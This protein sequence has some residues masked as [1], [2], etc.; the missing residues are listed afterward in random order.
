MTITGQ[1]SL[2][3]ED[4]E[5]MVRDAE[6]HAEDDRRR[7]EEAEV[8]NN[9]DTLVYQTEKLLRE[10]GEKAS[11]EDKTAIED[12]LK[13]V[14]EALAGT[15]VDAIKRAHEGLISA[16]QNFA[17]RLYQQAAAQAQ[18]TGGTGGAPG[19]GQTGPAGGTAEEEVADA[20]IVDE[21]RG[22]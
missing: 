22:A 5:R 4:I 13:S 2:N 18:A 10:Q 17:S 15:D 6:A 21:G 9:A 8:R 7:R 20:E 14:K 11:P 1:S 16:S 19:D 3:R 12:A